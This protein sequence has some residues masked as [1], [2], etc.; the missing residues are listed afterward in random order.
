MR[1]PTISGTARWFRLALL[2]LAVA[3]PLAA[4]S[5]GTVRGRVLDIA[6]QQP[7]ANAQISVPGTNAG[8][9]TNQNGD[10]VIANVPSGDHEIVARRVGYSRRSQRVTIPAGGEVRADFGLSQTISQLEAIVVTGTAGGAEKRT[11]GN[12]ITQLNVSDLSTKSNV[13]NLM[14]VLQARSPGVQIQAGSGTVGTAP[15]IRIRGAGGFTVSPP[16]VF[17]DGVRMST[18]G[19]GN[20]AP[21]GQGLAGNS[22][23][24]GLNALDLLNP[25]DIESIEI[26]KGPAAATLYGAD[27]AGGVIQV[28]TKKGSRGQQN[29]EWTAHVDYGQNDLG[30]VTLPTAYTT[31][32][33]TKIAAKQSDGTPLWPGCQGVTVGTILTA[34]PLRDDPTAMRDGAVRRYSGSAR[35]GGD[36]FSY[37]LS[38]DHSYEEGVLYN[39]FDR[40]NSLRSNFSYTPDQ[41]T[42][43]QIS[44]GVTDARVRQPLDGESAQGL[45][46]GH[47]RAQPGRAS[48]LPGYPVQ[49]WPFVTPAQSNQYDNQTHSDRATVGATMN[50]QPVTWLR[51]RLT[52]G[53]D[54]TYGTAT[55]FAPPNTPNLT[56]DTLG[57]TA[58]RVPRNTLYTLDYT[59]SIEHPFGANF[60]T[61][62]AFGSQVVAS[63][64]E[65]LD[66]QGIGL[67]TPDVKLIGNTTTITA[68]NTFSASN[69]V[70]YFLQEQVG[71]KNRI[72]ATVADRVDNSSVF[73]SKI[74]VIHYPKAQLS[75][76]LSEEPGLRRYFDML[77]ANSFKFR[78]A[79]GQAGKAPSPFAA[80]RTYVISVATVGTSTASAIRTGSFGNPGL[81]PEKGEEIEVGFD[82]DLFKGRAGLDFTWYSK[83]MRDVLVSTAIAPSTGFGGSQLANLGAVSNKGIEMSLTVTP[84]QGRDFN[85]DSRLSLS[86]NQNK[87]LSFGDPTI[88]KQ[89][90]FES[91]GSV[92]QHRVGYP[93]GGYWA[94]Y[95]KR[96]PDGSLLLVNGAIGA[97]SI[98]DTSYIGPAQ[99]TREV[100]FSNTFG[101]L[102]DFAVYTLFDYKGGNYNYR[103]AELYRCASSANCIERNDPNF[104]ASELPI[105]LAGTSINPRAVYIHKADFVKLRD[106]SLTYS[107]PSH[108]ASRLSAARASVTLAG[109]NLA[110]WSDY[111]G[112]DPE[113]NT[114]G[115]QAA[116][117]GS[118]NRGDIYAMPMTRRLTASVNLTY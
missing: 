114:Y 20:F 53:L 28:I 17:I 48:T 106:V 54:W 11:L 27:A 82:A 108:L 86:T 99:P 45:L 37:Y 19:L 110:I 7:L 49:G 64:A 40:R 12:A 98:A 71:W 117:T 41:K 34:S 15:D 58:Q 36:R 39:N 90:P 94:P 84:I 100:S 6:S 55:L 112:P 59:G 85:W 32:D 47:N 30:S 91:Y 63:R 78:T 61:T 93:L 81:K 52:L 2:S 14:D 22:G 62:T 103:G 9:L 29:T 38:G 109:H 104:P 10:F 69:S 107:L 76:I 74:N 97:A 8:A 66:A 56:G 102:R 33:A 105:Y 115:A 118:F 65:R 21:S 46:F 18:A 89:I 16:I 113:V 111:P 72:F 79:W 4:Q 83:Q 51:N 96:N 75:W 101:F 13:N 88:T 95:P 67:G 73:G 25:G 70:G 80:T 77:Q 50:Y 24:Q 3:S 57:L 92:Q 26:V 44:V 1:A 87:L 31:C 23:G 5:T 35:G 43:F 42:D 68:S 60:N 116:I